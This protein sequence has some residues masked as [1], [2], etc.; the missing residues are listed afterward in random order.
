M[1][2]A[3]PHP[4][5]RGDGRARDTVG[6]GETILKHLWA[7]LLIAGVCLLLLR[8]ASLRAWLLGNQSWLLLNHAA[9]AQERG[10]PAEETARQAV[11][12]M[13]RAAA[14][15]PENEAL[16]RGLGYARLGAGETA[17]ALVAWQDADGLA[18]EMRLWGD[19][20][21]AQAEYA[22]AVAW[23]R[24]AL[25]LAPV[26]SQ[27]V[28][29]GLGRAYME[30]D[31]P[32]AAVEAFTAGL[33]APAGSVGQSALYFYLGRVYQAHG[34]PPQR[35]AAVDAYERA[36]TADD[37]GSQPWLQVATRRQ[38]GNLLAA[39]QRWAEAV[40]QFEQ[41]L[42]LDGQD[43]WTLVDLAAVLW[44]SGQKAEALA[45]A[46]QATRLQPET[47]EAYLRL[48]NFYRDDGNL[49]QAE[50]MYVRVL[51]L[52]PQDSRAGQALQALRQEQP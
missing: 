31:A 42:A 26:A 9:R 13:E 25:A 48:G 33:A 34:D 39:E 45:T 14:L 2:G 7:P 44:Q 47:K 30:Q 8:G 19:R 23:Y 37:F 17:A 51:A 35:E 3:T 29:Y 38:L 4:V 22:T 52:D 46:Q 36:L 21:L 49:A 28:W 18:G 12:Q 27:D 11:S 6:Q 41:A 20:A 40:A 32:A 15:A 24:R 10:A 1:V 5:S 50:A 16:Q 43:Y